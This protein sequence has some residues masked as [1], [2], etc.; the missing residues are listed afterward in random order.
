VAGAVDSNVSAAGLS[1][2]PLCSAS[3]M[4]TQVTRR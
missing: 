1:A 3:D 4:G 2:P